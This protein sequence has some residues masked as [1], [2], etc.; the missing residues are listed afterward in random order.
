MREK[1]LSIKVIALLYLLAPLGNI[2]QNAFFN[3]WPL[4]GPRSVFFH[5]SLYEW[6]V[7]AVFPV[8]AFGIWR[9]AMWGYVSCMGFAGFLILHN[10]YGYFSN[11]AYS[12]YVVLLFQMCIFALVGIFLQK[13]IMAPYFNPNIRWWENE[14]RYK[15]DL[16]AQLR[17]EQKIQNC[18]VLDIS[19]S[20]CFAQSKKEYALGDLVWITINL[21]ET[22]VTCQA[23]IVWVKDKPTAGYGLRFTQ[24]EKSE[25]VKIKSLIK[26]L[27]KVSKRNVGRPETES[28][29]SA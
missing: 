15:V 10:I 6:M 18:Q 2:L 27:Q 19:V 9:V 16:T 3:Q 25:Q 28:S 21:D 1:P 14:P 26:H 8:V 12:P 13:H 23:K 5:L 22:H 11:R 4:R 20:G 29:Q 17:Q 7:L 24:M